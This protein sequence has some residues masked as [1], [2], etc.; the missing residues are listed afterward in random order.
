MRNQRIK[1]RLAI[2]KGLSCRVPGLRMQGV[3][4][5]PRDG[6]GV[7]LPSRSRNQKGGGEIFVISLVLVTLRT[8]TLPLLA[9]PGRTRCL[10][11]IRLYGERTIRLVW[12]T[13][14]RRRNPSSSVVSSTCVGIWPDV[15]ASRWEP[16]ASDRSA[17]WNLDQLH[18]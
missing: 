11:R 14:T 3:C 7:S 5:L 10:P 15:S 16:P 17:S 6:R 4:G 9:G 8:D 12:K 2:S 1:G 13:A 18:V